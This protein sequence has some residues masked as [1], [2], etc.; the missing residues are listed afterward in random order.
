MVTINCD[1]WAKLIKGQPLQVRDSLISSSFYQK[2]KSIPPSVVIDTLKTCIKCNQD[3]INKANYYR[4]T[5]FVTGIPGLLLLGTY[6]GLKLGGRERPQLM[7]YSGLGLLAMGLIFE[8]IGHSK[9]AKE[10]TAYNAHLNAPASSAQ[11]I[12]P[13]LMITPAKDSKIEGMA[14]VKISF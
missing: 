5:G 7:M 8:R 6:Y 11:K 4:T 1:C 3:E 14:G 12:K 13:M 9:L 2:D 10:V